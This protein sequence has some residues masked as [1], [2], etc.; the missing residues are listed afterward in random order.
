[1][2]NR[3]GLERFGWQKAMLKETGHLF[4]FIRREINQMMCKKNYLIFHI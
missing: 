1:M 3:F 2:Y 4:R